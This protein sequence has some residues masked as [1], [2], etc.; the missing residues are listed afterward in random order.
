M[1]NK[2]VLSEILLGLMPYT[3]QN[4]K[5]ITKPKQFIYDLERLKNRNKRSVQCALSRAENYG[6]L[7]ITDKVITITDKGLNYL[8]EFSPDK[9]LGN[10]G[11]MVV[12]DI[13]EQKRVRRNQ[14][15]DYLKR[16]NFV[17]VQKSVWVSNYDLERPVRKI[18]KKL[19]INEDVKIYECIAR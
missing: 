1:R 10:V 4:G 13:P 3:G 11:L 14:F 17:Q 9:L 15:R 12:F 16:L 5:L 2:S 18:A 6:Y 19:L 7:D 8:D